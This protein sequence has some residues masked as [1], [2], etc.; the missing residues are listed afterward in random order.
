MRIAQLVSLEMPVPP[1]SQ[2]GLEFVVS[3][4]T[5]EL[6]K[7]G[8]EVSLFGTEDSR[9]EGRL[10]SLIP[11]K[12]YSSHTHNWDKPLPE[13]W[14]M[15][16]VAAHS[17]E[18]DIIHS[19]ARGVSLFTPF[20]QAPVV[21]TLHHPFRDESWLPFFKKK[22]Y[23]EQMKYIFDSTSKVNYVAVSKNQE[24]QFTEASAYFKKHTHIHNGIPMKKFPFNAMPKDYLLYIGY[25]NANKG[26][27]IAVEVAKK[28]G[29]KL[30]LA[31]NNY[32]EEAFF[33]KHIKPYLNKDIR[34]V[35]PVDFKTKIS[36]Y[37]NAVA[38]LAPITW[39]EPFGLTIVES[40]ACGTPVIAFDKGASAEIIR[41]GV[42]GFIV[43]DQ[44]E[45]L[46]AVKK[47]STLDRKACRA[48]AE[49]NFSVEHMVDQYEALYK[50]LIAKKR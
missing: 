35:G 43:K 37:K 16:Y 3:W 49:K 19:H 20:M 29:M 17:K 2:N 13:Y 26:A 36:L 15:S 28:L 24:K 14:N 34:Y 40:Q 27:H 31:G 12:I 1:H 44:K 10:I 5:E 18:F 21:Q 4:I 39:D 41:D 6:V 9:T 33:N 46:Q 7:R 22:K 38:K 8:H 32:G 47:I 30:I 50:S 42:T 45:M 48:W 11:K 23:A 25:I